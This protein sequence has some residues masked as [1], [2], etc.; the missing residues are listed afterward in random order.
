MAAILLELEVLVRAKKLLPET[1]THGISPPERRLVGHPSVLLTSPPGCSNLALTSHHFKIKHFSISVQ[2]RG[3]K[4]V[5][6][7]ALAVKLTKCH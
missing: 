4:T 6:L 3:M 5:A 7:L 2:K 1:G